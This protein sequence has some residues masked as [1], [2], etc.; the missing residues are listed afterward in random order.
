[1]TFPLLFLMSVSSMVKKLIFFSF[2]FILAITSSSF[3]ILISTANEFFLASAASIISLM[4]YGSSF[5]NCSPILWRIKIS[6]SMSSSLND[7]NSSFMRSNKILP[8]VDLKIK[9][10]RKQFKIFLSFALLSS[11]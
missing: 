4:A 7:C 6:I 11:S 3:S 10:C 1:M 8:L 5:L 2:S 9:K